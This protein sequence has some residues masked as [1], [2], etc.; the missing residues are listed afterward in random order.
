MS[1]DVCIWNGVCTEGTRECDR[2]GSRINSLDDTG[3][4]DGRR[5]RARGRSSCVRLGSI[6]CSCQFREVARA[7]KQAAVGSGNWDATWNLLLLLVVSMTRKT[8]SLALLTHP[9]FVRWVRPLSDA[10]LKAGVKR[11]GGSEEPR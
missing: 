2:I 3:Q 5:G 4:E 1:R 11:R 10:L 7:G 8:A 6:S 9:F